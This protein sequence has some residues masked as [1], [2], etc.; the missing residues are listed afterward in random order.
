MPELR[1]YQKEDV[2]FLE[3]LDAVGIFNE[4]RTGE[5]LWKFGN[6]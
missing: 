3:K 2:L 1:H 4:M 6:L 5:L